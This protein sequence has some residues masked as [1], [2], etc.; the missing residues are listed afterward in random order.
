M[1]LSYII[2]RKFCQAIT[3]ALWIPQKSSCMQNFPFITN[4]YIMCNIALN[5]LFTSHKICFKDN[6][7]KKQV[8]FSTPFT[9]VWLNDQK[10]FISLDAIVFGLKIIV[11]FKK[12]FWLDIFGF[13]SFS[14]F[15]SVRFDLVAYQVSTFYHD[16]NFSEGF[17]EPV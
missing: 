1:C 4:K 9:F 15:G 3:R 13:F 2:G 6:I 5:L 17:K 10:V 8:I 12:R 7:F 11:L 14:N 16:W